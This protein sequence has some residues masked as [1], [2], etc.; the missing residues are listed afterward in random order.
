MELIKYVRDGRV[1]IEIVG[2]HRESKQFNATHSAI[3]EMLA[4]RDS[5]HASNNH[6]RHPRAALAE[7]VSRTFHHT[8]LPA[9]TF[10]RPEFR[11][12]TAEEIREI[13]ADLEMQDTAGG[14]GGSSV[15]PNNPPRGILRETRWT[16]LARFRADL[17][18]A[19]WRVVNSAPRARVWE[20]IER[21]AARHQLVWRS[22][23]L[24]A[25]GERNYEDARA[26]RG[27]RWGSVVYTQQRDEFIILRLQ[28]DKEGSLSAK[29]AEILLVWKEIR[30][31]VRGDRNVHYGSAENNPPPSSHATVREAHATAFESPAS[32]H[33]GKDRSLMRSPPPRGSRLVKRAQNNSEDEDEDSSRES[34]E[35]DNTS[36]SDSSNSNE[37]EESSQDDTE[38]DEYYENSESN[39]DSEEEYGDAFEHGQYYHSI[40]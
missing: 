10:T 7:E 31:A 16:I 32:Y 21:G 27:E 28:K 29:R 18:P 25:A 5:P 17:L 38:S 15:K 37:S 3:L 13:R 11:I 19:R 12:A 33:I 35:E 26:D 4:E 1:Q 6:D 23:D 2:A 24:S 9:Q 14:P 22:R 8:S 39:T 36:A 34:G 30:D 40:Q 20:R